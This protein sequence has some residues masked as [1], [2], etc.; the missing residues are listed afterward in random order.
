VVE[1]VREVVVKRSNS[2]V[3]VVEGGERRR[4]NR[5]RTKESKRQTHTHKTENTSTHVIEKYIL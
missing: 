2:G 4:D 1:E 5:N 3:V